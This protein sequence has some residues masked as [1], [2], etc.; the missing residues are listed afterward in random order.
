MNKFTILIIIIVLV[1]GVVVFDSFNDED[2]L[3]SN[4]ETNFEID[5]IKPPQI[6]DSEGD[7]NTSNQSN[8]LIIKNQRTVQK[9]PKTNDDY[10]YPF[11]KEGQAYMTRGELLMEGHKHVDTD[12]YSP[13]IF[14]Q[15]EQAKY[16]LKLAKEI[17]TLSKKLYID[18]D[19]GKIIDQDV[20]KQMNE[21][22]KN[23]IVTVKKQQNIE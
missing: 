3:Q 9:R 5:V 17:S 12:K 2:P 7:I 8:N 13:D 6:V 15:I 11:T 23:L 22:S 16:N 19:E 10:E 4:D 1:L 18:T 20:Y 14:K 21:L